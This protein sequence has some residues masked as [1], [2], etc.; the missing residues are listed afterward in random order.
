M[1]RIAENFWGRKLSWILRFCGYTRKFS[2][3]TLGCGILWRGKS[4]QSANVFSVKIVFSPIHESFP[5]YSTCM[6]CSEFQRLYVYSPCAYMYMYMYTFFPNT[7]NPHS[8][9]ARS[10]ACHGGRDQQ[11]DP[12][13]RHRNRRGILRVPPPA[14]EGSHGQGGCGLISS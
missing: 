9:T 12:Q 4:V 7:H 14:A 10:T 11:E 5:L 8:L 2:P 3:Q 13:G 1:Y 6:Y